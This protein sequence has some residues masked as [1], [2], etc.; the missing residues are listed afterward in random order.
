MKAY[1]EIGRAMATVFT[2]EV[3]PCVGEGATSGKV[4]AAVASVLDAGSIS[5]ESRGIVFI[6]KANGS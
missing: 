3:S 1:H 5:G 6:G 4:L 2:D